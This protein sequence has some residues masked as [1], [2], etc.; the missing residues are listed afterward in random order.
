MKNP[1]ECSGCDIKLM[2][3]IVIAIIEV[4]MKRTN[5]PFLVADPIVLACL[6][7][8]KENKR[9]IVF[10]CWQFVCTLY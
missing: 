4:E 8:I 5:T 10:D 2:R 1:I 7:L 9:R 6:V 3:P